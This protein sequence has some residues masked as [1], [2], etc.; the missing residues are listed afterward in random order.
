MFHHHSNLVIQISQTDCSRAF[1]NHTFS[2]ST[3]RCIDRWCRCIDRSWLHPSSSNLY[4]I[5]KRESWMHVYIHHIIS[6]YTSKYTSTRIFNTNHKCWCVQK[7]ESGFL[8][9]VWWPEHCLQ[10]C[11]MHYCCS[12]HTT[13]E[14]W[15]GH[16]TTL[17]NPLSLFWTLQQCW[18]MLKIQFAMYFDIER[19]DVMDVCMY[20]TFSLCYPVKMGWWWMDRSNHPWPVD[21]STGQ[22]AST[23]SLSMWKR[24][25]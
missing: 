20:S 11:V 3:C 10:W 19:D 21:A 17:W 24:M 8:G 14:Q 23:G 4:W 25:Q 9:V 15:S 1:P 22:F 7:R 6:I 2:E 18:L 13:W 5:T 12:S 16:H